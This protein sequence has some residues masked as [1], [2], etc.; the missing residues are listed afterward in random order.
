MALRL[1]FLFTSSCA[2]QSS[3]RGWVGAAPFLPKSLGVSTMPRPKCQCQRRFTITR[4]VRGFSGL[5]IH[6][7]NASRRP[8]VG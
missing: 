2:S 8:L 4:A 5:A 7:A 1:Q 6:F 3:R